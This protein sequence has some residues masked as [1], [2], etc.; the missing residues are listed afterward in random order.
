MAMRLRVR[1]RRYAR[2]M[3]R[4]SDVG[5]VVL[6]V[7]IA[8]IIALGVALIREAVHG[9]H[10]LLFEVPIEAHLSGAQAIPLW[11]RLLVP[12]LGG[13]VYGLIAAALWRWRPRDVVDAIEANALHGGRMSLLD[14]FRLTLLTVLSGGVG[15]SWASKPHTRSS[16][17]APPRRSAGYS[18]CAATIYGFLWD[19]APP[20]RL[21][22]PLMPRL[23]APF[24]RSSF[25]G[26]Y[27]LATLVPVVAAAVVAT[28]ITRTLFDEGPIFIVFTQ[29]DLV[30]RHYLIL[31]AIGVL[32]GLLAIGVMVGVTRVEQAMRRITLMNCARPALGGLLVGIGALA[33]PEI[34]GSGHGGILHTI[35]RGSSGFEL[36]MLIGLILAKAAASAV[37]IGSGFRGGMFSSSLFLGALFGAA[38]SMM[39]SRVLPW[40]PP[41]T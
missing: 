25:I 6:A 39:V 4:D 11:R 8:V 10:H 36:P 35:A 38:C 24:M 41:T 29:P 9:L 21:P 30:V 13:L 15:A 34:L 14:S 3:V 5:R 7:A 37:S 28:L 40:A 20:R 23:P 2:R 26:S 31:A 22:P 19:A 1:L 17:P 16:V 33:F 12:S 18:S 32:A 27:T